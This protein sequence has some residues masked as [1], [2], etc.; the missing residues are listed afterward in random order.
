M[1]APALVDD[2]RLSPDGRWL[3]ALIAQQLHVIAAPDSDKPVDLSTPGLAHRRIT[4]V[5]ADF[6]E[7]A[8]G[9][10]TITWAV[11]STFYRRAL[12]DIDLNPAEK[13]DWGAD[14]PSE[15][16]TQAFAMT[17]ET[18]RDTPRGALLLTGARVLTMRGDEVLE[19]A[20][21]LIR[22]D[23]IAA[24]GARG[25]VEAPPGAAVRD[26]AGKTLAPGYI[27]IH[28]HVADIRRGVLSTESWGLRARLAY[29]V[30]TAFDP[31]SLSIDMFAYQDLID[32]GVVA[33]SRLATTGMAMF[34]F[35]RLASPAD[36]RALVSRHRDHYRTRNAKQYLIGN[37][38]QRQWLAQAAK[39]LGV[40]PT[41]E[42]SLA[43]KLDLS[44]IMDGFAGSEHALPTA[45]YRDV[46]ELVARSG[47]A[48]DATLSIANGGP[49]ALDQ[50]IIRDRPL[51]DEK[52]LRT[53]PY[54]IAAA[55]VLE[56]QWFDP[57]LLVYPR[58]GF[59]AAKIQ[60]AGGV[61]GMGSHGEIPG[62]GLHWEMEAH[63]QGG[64]TP[65]EALRAATIGGAIAI[66]RGKQFGS[67]E[68]G[69]YADLV[70]LDADPRT[71]IRNARKLSYVM[72]NGRL[73][74]ANT[75]DEVWPR[76][77]RAETPWFHDDRPV[78]R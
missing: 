24:V 75:L 43:L 27:D 52:F 50:F 29:G 72:K 18:P 65:L 53:R 42:G 74:D 9:G 40:M 33:G 54:V 41:T 19:N 64:M 22:D 49:A 60:R 11:G 73:Y 76:Q 51:S 67:I 14:A 44:Q 31:S 32:A 48:Y 46:I 6:F 78:V 38:R 57:G 5:G 10:R 17:V 34:S 47:A 66:G 36:A 37:R 3:L 45:L 30:T 69:K 68:P 12:R 58:I 56:R 55:T 15:R 8:D 26:L 59:D 16:D 25:A 28:D 1:D 70:I 63:V 21:V 13:P 2:S 62:P 71:D 20:D 4:N 7:W 23:R 61:V 35:N 77:R 39:E